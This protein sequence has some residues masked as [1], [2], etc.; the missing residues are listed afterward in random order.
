MK[1][2]AHT[3]EEIQK[4][5]GK[6]ILPLNKG[7]EPFMKATGYFGYQ[8]V[9]LYDTVEDKIQCH[10]CGKWFKQITHDHLIHRDGIEGTAEYKEMF[11]LYKSTPLESIGS[12]KLRSDEAV[13]TWKDDDARR[14]KLKRIN[15]DAQ[16]GGGRP[17][18]TRQPAEFKN[19]KGICDAQLKDRAEK[20]QE[21]L[22]RELVCRDDNA[23]SCALRRRYGSFEKAK[24]ILKLKYEDK[25]KR[26]M[27]GFMFR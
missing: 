2:Q 19:G 22:G 24:K 27:F 6:D 14:A 11:G 18:G 4:E 13:K 3:L 25:P 26:N 5:Y 23:L 16:R 17:K 20:L 7:V 21:K 1:I 10:A 15:K 9:L 8:G 12:R